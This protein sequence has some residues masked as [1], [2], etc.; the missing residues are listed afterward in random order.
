MLRARPAERP[1][2]DASAP[3]PGAGRAASTLLPRRRRIRRVLVGLLVTLM[4]LSL[5]VTAG[6][7]Y[8]QHRLTSQIGRIEG[9][10]EGLEESER[11]TVF[12]RGRAPQAVNILLMGT[13]RRSSVATT[14]AGAAAPSWVPGAQ[15]T[16]ALMLLHI[17]GDRRGATVVSLPRDSWVPV[18]GYGMAKI[19]AAF[20]YAGPSLAVR[21]VEQ[22]TN[23]RIDHLAVIDWEGFRQLTDAVGGVTVTVPS[24]VFDS[25]RGVTWTAGQHTL[26]GQQ[27]LDYVGQRYGLPNGDL[28]RVRRQQN[29]LRA[30]MEDHLRPALRS[31]PRLVY[32]FLDIATRNLSVDEEWEVGDMADL[33]FSLR[34]LRTDDV[35]FLTVP[36]LGLGREGDQSVV[37][38][39]RVRGAGLWRT[40]RTDRVQD[41]LE[42][43][44]ETEIGHVVP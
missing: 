11:P 36:V 8:L 35:N 22:L 10:F 41:W 29:F 21:T 37:Y 7:Y 12:T 20:S 17:D 4:V 38:L 1:A 14:G 15:R 6:A 13:D 34:H 9:V 23:V 26:T 40:V 43:H 31:D 44:P 30:L 39:D 5:G 33:A 16:D 19:N 18:P 27:A 2:S 24:T 28:D 32:A 3:P 42:G 25:A